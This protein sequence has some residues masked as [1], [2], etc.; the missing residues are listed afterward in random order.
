VIIPARCPTRLKANSAV[1]VVSS[2]VTAAVLIAL[3]GT[4]PAASAA[5]PSNARAGSLEEITVTAS[6]RSQTTEEVPYAISVVSPE[7][8]A[9]N[10]VTDLNTLMR[11][12][13]VSG[14]AGA[15][16][17][18]VSF[19]IIRGLNASPSAASFRTFEQQPVG[20]YFDNSPIEGYFQLQDIQRIE[21][22]RGPQGTLYGAGALGGALRVIPNAPELGKFSGTFDGRLGQVEHAS[23]PSYTGSAVINVPLGDT[24]AFR[25]AGNYEKQPGFIDVA[26]LMRREGTDGAPLLADP[27]D[28]VNS[29]G[30]YYSKKDWNDQQTFTG[31]ASALWQPTD[32]FTAQIAFTHG[33]ADG[34][35]NPSNNSLFPGGPNVIDP[36]ITLPPGGDY[37]Q[38]ASTEQNY[39]RTT[40][41]TSL[42]LSYDVGFAT[43][44]STTSYLDTEGEF[45]TDTNYLL[46]QPLLVAFVPYYAGLPINPRWINTNHTD[47][48]AHAF[49]QEIR[50]VSNTG[51]EKK[52]DYVLGAFYQKQMRAGVFANFSPGTPER[53]IAQGCVLPVLLGG[54]A[55]ITGPN[56]AA[57]YQ[58][59]RQEF[60]D[61]SVF[62]ELTWHFAPNW[63]AT[64]GLRRFEQ[65][66]TDTARSI[67]YTFGGI[68]SGLNTK[69]SSVSKTLGKFGVSWEYMENQHIYTLWS[70]G[71]RRGG[72]NGLL[73]PTGPFADIAPQEYK[74][75]TVDNY[76]IGFKGRAGA[77]SYTIDA[78][79]IDWKDPQVSGLTP[80][81]NFAVWNAKS[82]ESK[83]IEF[84]LNTPLGIPGLS[85]MAS[86]T[87]ADATLTED[88]LIPDILG[89]I[90]GKK[91]QQLPGSPKKSAAA[92]LLY[93][94]D[95]GADSNLLLTLNDT[96]T[97]EIVTSIFAVL[98]VRPITSPSLNLLNASAAI[99]S[100]PWNYGIYATNVTNKRVILGRSSPNDAFSYQET[101]NRP[102][103]IYLRASYSF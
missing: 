15:R 101:A 56:S 98:G 34:H 36:R 62:G 8:I 57:N 10:S 73:L 68:D 69:S 61:K 2:P 90:V 43:V 50:L 99:T 92:T 16:T 63:Q 35:G 55:P 74:P 13:G 67:L 37:Q 51:P 22:L 76:E 89:D 39:T 81:A 64:A 60:E 79:Y 1:A 53:A 65:D 6:R 91:G 14:A 95:L 70:Q 25:V 87:Y 42:D 21:V 45:R 7:T 18:S 40:Q 94:L 71:F 72:A 26:G 54:C 4:P 3:F 32:A 82:A 58:T 85:L 96:Y 52:W 38:F 83:G 33:K 5:E 23:D 17:S 47:D 24:F 86:G 102:R 78:F 12:I 19:P 93:S 88:Y 30:V 97:S 44:S 84:D 59:D 9:M 48:N 46:M 103:E 28:P 77:I 80:N 49:S 31:R 20:V 75:D 27:S 29:P 11:Q 66:F 41:L 100:G